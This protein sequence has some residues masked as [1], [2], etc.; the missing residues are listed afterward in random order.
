MYPFFVLR[1]TPAFHEWLRF[2]QNFSAV[3]FK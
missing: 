3:R 2:W 1:Y